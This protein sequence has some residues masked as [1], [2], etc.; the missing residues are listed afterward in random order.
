MTATPDHSAAEKGLL[1]LLAELLCQLLVLA[2]PIFLVSLLPPDL[3]LAGTLICAGMMWFSV[4]LGSVRAARGFSRLMISAV[5]GLGFSLG[6]GLPEY[7]NIAAAL[8]SILCGLACVSAWERRLGL[9]QRTIEP[10]RLSAWGGNEPR[11]TPE[12]E[13]IRV[14]NH[15][16]IAMGG[17]VFCDYL[18]PDGVLLQGIGASARFSSDGRYFAAPVPSR[19]TW[20]LVILD[21]QL[22][23]V[24]RCASDDFWELD[25][26][27]DGSLSG[28]YSPQADNGSRQ[29]S[30]ATLL[31]AA[32]AVDLLPIADL[33]L[34]PGDWQD[35]VARERFE[36]RSTD[37]RQCLQ[38]RIALPAS[39]RDLPQPTDLLRIAQY[40]ISINGEPCALLIR[41]D[42]PKVWSD[43]GRAL[44]CLAREALQHSAPAS[45]WLW[46]I[47]KGW[48][49]LPV[50]WVVND[51]EPSLHWHPLLTLD[52]RELR[53]GACLD[54]AQPEHGHHGYRLHSIHSD[55]QTR[56][57][58]D[59]QG[60]LQVAELRLTRIRLA[61]PL[62]SKG[63][64]GATEVESEPLLGNARARL[65]WLEDN[66]DGL[67]AYCCRIGDWRLP[68]QW[69]LEH[70][71]SDCGRYLALLPFTRPPAMA[72]H[73]VV[74]DTLQQRLLES[75]P[76]L[77]ARI[78]DFRAGKLSLAVILGRLAQ[79]LDGSPLQRFDQAAPDA[80]EA[81]AFCRHHGNSRLYYQTCELQ[82]T[83]SGLQPL[84][85][86]R[87][88]DT[89][90][91]AIADGNFIQPAPNA[92]D[93]AWLFGSETEYADSW[94]RANTPRLGGY[95][96]TASGCALR[97]LAPS[98][99]WSQDSRYLA[100]SRLDTQVEDHLHNHRAW[101]LL[102]LDLHAR[103]LRISPQ[104]LRHRV[105]FERFDA[106][107]L[108]LRLYIR[109]WETE[110]DDDQGSPLAL[111]L[112]ELLS[113]TP[114]PLIR[115]DGIWLRAG[116]QKD[117]PAWQTLDLPACRY[118][119]GL[120][121]TTAHRR[122]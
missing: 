73:V 26:F 66:S 100:L 62:D 57:G 56:I 61:M 87:L 8:G 119:E 30:L 10:D 92:Q 120:A 34:E 15:G 86:W 39:L 54:C 48:R 109:D 105:Q 45:Y 23:R 84:P 42:A 7:W 98:M 110:D 22:R 107:M 89:P 1:R 25:T 117:A 77:A 43:D 83:D 65:S 31:K 82:L 69:L 40:R 103:T 55:T 51:R 79:G 113:L 108:Q 111:P 19:H 118:F 91:V 5:F 38:G 68:G 4:R 35:V 81:G 64:R 74:V 6:R 17:P 71:V 99:I 94:L 9:A 33:W 106:D 50:P 58:H 112:H 29:S 85:D 13:P 90:Q 78:L 14:F 52:E 46:H 2:L 122:T 37:G 36:Y 102:L 20:G 97:D 93:A 49:P 104:W 12:G 11:Q 60:R 116:D 80:S 27:N 32:T 28:R 70:R 16:E 47:D 44:A 96:L 115:H 95:L 24:Y 76:L 101:Q 59:P 72:G 75:P 21:R 41:A 121:K 63:Q 18:F 114:E 3:A 67:G 88:V 53:I